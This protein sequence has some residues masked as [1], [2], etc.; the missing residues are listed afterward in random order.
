M[1]LLDHKAE[2]A[3]VSNSGTGTVAVLNLESG[4][5]KTIPVGENPQ[6][7]VI[8][9]DGKRVYVTA[10]IGNS[11]AIIDTEKQELRGRIETGKGPGRVAL[12]PDEKTLVYNMQLG[13]R[14]GFADV[15]T[16]KQTKEV[17]LPGH[18]LSLTLSADGQTAYLGIQDIDKI[19]IASVPRREIVKVFDTPRESGP[20][21][22]LELR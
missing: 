8:T 3:Y 2:F 21:P 7:A 6:G 16:M 13:E 19:V 14:L 5:V 20:D 17:V 9:R 11:I 18:P 10:S 22:V 4:T 12:T 15:A 1:V